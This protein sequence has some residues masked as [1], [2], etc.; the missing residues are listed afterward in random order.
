VETEKR[1]LIEMNEFP[2]L[3]NFYFSFQT[4]SKLY[5]ILE[6]CPGGELF[7]LL[8]KRGKFT[9][10]QVKFYSSQVVVALEHLHSKHILYRDLKP[11]NIL[12]DVDGYLKIT[13]FGLSQLN[14]HDN[15]ALQICGTPEYLAPEIVSNKHYG[16][17]VDW[18]CLGCLIYELLTGICPFSNPDR[19]L[20]FEQIKFSQPKIPKFVSCEGR[21]L[22]MK[23]FSKN[24][25][26]RLGS[27]GGGQVRNHPWF[28]VVNWDY[29][30]NKHYDPP[31]KPLLTENQGLMYFNKEFTN[32]PA[33]SLGKNNTLG[34]WHFP[35]FSFTVESKTN[36]RDFAD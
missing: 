34:D 17:P 29:L 25:D 19:H 6:Y 16:K 14:V 2:F 12:V 33:E 9:E 5:F 26:K 7:E 4:E 18:W 36:N 22:L 30:I 8:Q 24:P 3:I 20:L 23:L 27:E 28:Q 10:D 15:Q 11:E 13:D 31:F 21:D 35:G 1:I 32:L